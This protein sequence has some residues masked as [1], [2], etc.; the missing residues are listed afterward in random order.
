[1]IYRN[2][3]VPVDGSE[4]AERGLQEAIRLARGEERRSRL[5]HIV[6]EL[7]LLSPNAYGMDMGSVFRMLVMGGEEV[8][9]RAEAT[10]KKAGID[11][12]TVLFEAMGGQAGAHIVRKALDWPA[13]LIVCGTHGRR[14]FRRMVLGSDAEYVVRHTP[15]PV[16][17]VRAV[18]PA[19]ERELAE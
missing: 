10:V 12:D 19:A 7:V 6:N 1:M 15:V 3:L 2:I 5:V 18:G 13:D 8:L 16:L 11:V 4:T 17:L 9:D 14:G